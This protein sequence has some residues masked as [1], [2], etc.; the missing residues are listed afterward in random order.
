MKIFRAVYNNVSKIAS[1]IIHQFSSIQ[2]LASEGFPKGYIEPEIMN[3][4]G[5]YPEG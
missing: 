2:K 3:V 1:I 5:L 4:R